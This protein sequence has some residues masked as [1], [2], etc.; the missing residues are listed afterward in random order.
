ME[1]TKASDTGSS[2]SED[3]KWIEIIERWKESGLS[4]AEWVRN[5]EGITYY[6]FIFHRN[7]LFPE[8]IKKN[9]FMEQELSWS[10]V[11]VTFPSTLNVFVQDCRI[12]VSP[13]FDQELL[14]E[15]VEVLKH[16]HPV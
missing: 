8:D 11:N 15:V 5:Q 12:E 9:E 14:R 6:Q 16:V 2:S 3:Q 7:R 13:G 4:I 10:S 1:V